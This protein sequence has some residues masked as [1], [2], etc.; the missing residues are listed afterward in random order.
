MHRKRQEPGSRGSPRRLRGW[1]QL[2][3][4]GNQL[5]EVG[6]CCSCVS[7]AWRV[8]GS[9]VVWGACNGLMKFFGC[10]KWSSHGSLF[11]AMAELTRYSIRIVSPFDARQCGSAYW[12]V[13]RK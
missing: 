10:D 5:R 2:N 11:S 12:G 1:D 7:T 13:R 4:Q 3:E 6:R 9:A 8:G